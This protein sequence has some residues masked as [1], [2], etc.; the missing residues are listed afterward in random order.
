MKRFS[1]LFFLLL[2]LLVTMMMLFYPQ[3]AYD[4]ACRGLETWTTHLLPSLL[5]FFIAADL[6]LSMGF[7]R[8]LGVLLEPV[9][10][11]LFRLPGEAGFAV[12]LGF[13][14]GFP[15]GAIL[16][17]SLK[18][19]KLCTAQEAARLAAF[20]NNSSPLFLLISVPISML[21]QPQLG[22]L[23]LAAHYL[24]NLTIGI[25]LRFTAP[26]NRQFIVPRH[27]LR[28][29]FAQM[30]QYQAQHRQPLGA[31]LGQAVQ[32]GIDSIVKIGGF[33]LLF[34]VLLSLLQATGLLALL[35][36][37][38]A[39]VLR[40]FQVSPDLS[41]A[42]SAGLFE[43]T[44]GAQTAA[45]S[46]AVLLQ[47]LMVISFILGWSGLS[48]QAQVSSILAGRNISARLYCLCR[49][50]QGFLAAMYIPL[51]TVLF[52]DILSV[53]ALQQTLP[54]VT[55]VFDGSLLLFPLA[56]LG[57]LLVLSACFRFCW[58]MRQNI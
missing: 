19:Q 28:S 22:A 43:M 8:F 4:G 2:V 41:A 5:P 40:L 17:A 11:P 6:L 51:L 12:A 47:K 9:M 57:T 53:G 7:V 23:L 55:P 3:A 10:R 20:T 25:L 1:A 15:M 42:L 37:L 50:V 44:L 58:R 35:Q 18:E 32:K 49:P 31:M 29:A 39:A 52:P 36:N 54:A 21:H 48:I 13:T 45:D 30:Q 34:S 33:V 27:L 46:E 56:A 16:T 24:A 14:S 26:P 38:F